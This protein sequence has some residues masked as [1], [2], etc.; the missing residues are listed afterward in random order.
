M[1]SDPPAPAWFRSKVS[2]FAS[3][4]TMRF[5]WPS[6]SGIDNYRV[7]YRAVGETDW[8]TFTETGF[9]NTFA[10]SDEDDALKVLDC[11]TLY[12]FRLRAHG[13]GTTFNAVWSTP[14]ASSSQVYSPDCPSA[15]GVPATPTGFTSTT[16]RGVY[17]ATLSWDDPQDDSITK[18]QYRLDGFDENGGIKGKWTNIPDSGAGTTS[19][20]IT[21]PQTDRPSRY[22]GFLRAVNGHGAGSPTSLR[23]VDI[24]W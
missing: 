10:Y 17:S 8:A 4:E 16:T 2:S 14:L 24:G 1:L 5:S 7:E 12:E 6:A 13:D 21:A 23:W 20:T 22:E 3:T 18:Y 11:E 9:P 15:A 19:Y